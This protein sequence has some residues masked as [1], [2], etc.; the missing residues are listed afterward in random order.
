MPG[1]GGR[2]GAGIG[3][4]MKIVRVSTSGQDLAAQRNGLAVLGVDDQ[5]VHVDHGLSGTTRARPGLRKALAACCAGGELVVTKVDR[6]ASS[7]RDVTHVADELTKR[8]V[9]LSLEKRFPTPSTP[10]ASCC[11]TSSGSWP[12]SKSTSSAPAPARAWRSRKPPPASSAPVSPSS[13]SRRKHLA[14]LHRTEVHSR[15][16][17]AK[18]FDVA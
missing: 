8:G 9:A 15:S 12:T 1:H 16:E 13:P 11:F 7:L 18:L 2:N 6:L 10:S 14:Q 3:R 5:R 17:T 4:S